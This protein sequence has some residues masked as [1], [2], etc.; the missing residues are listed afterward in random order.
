M[1]TKPRQHLGNNHMKRCL[2][3]TSLE[4]VGPVSFLSY[5]DPVPMRLCCFDMPLSETQANDSPPHARHERARLPVRIAA[6]LRSGT[7][8]RIRASLG[9]AEMLREP[10][11]LLC[12]QTD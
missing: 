1:L 12:Q 8:W 5:P 10:D 4:E 2:Q 9:R 6:T 3:K 7:R 11:R